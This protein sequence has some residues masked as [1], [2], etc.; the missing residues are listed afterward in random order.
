MFFRGLGTN[1]MDKV[2]FRKKI[3]AERGRIPEAVLRAKSEA[4][5]G[6]LFDAGLYREAKTIFCFVSIAGEPDTTPIIRQAFKDGKTLCVPRT[7]PDR[8]ME[9][10]P[11]GADAFERAFADW[12]RSFGIPE[13]PAI[14]QGWSL[15]AGE[16]PLIAGGS[17]LVSENGPVLCIV[18]SLAV[19]ADG[20]RLG[21]GGG[22]YDRLIGAYKRGQPE[23]KQTLQPRPFFAAIQLDQFY[24]T[25]KL[26]REPHDMSVDAIITEKGIMIIND[27]EAG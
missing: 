18:P 3:L 6:H 19:D 24:Y 2:S 17:S 26:P 15:I 12:P 14:L 25:K 7:C 16:A 11:V 13:P 4:A 5:A 20:Y 22:Y 27:Q 21:F 9:A 23:Q 1:Y 10:V 8:T